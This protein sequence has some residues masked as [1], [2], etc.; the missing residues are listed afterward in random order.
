MASSTWS[1]DSSTWSGNSYIW[2]NSTYQVTANM[3]QVNLSNAFG[4]DLD[5]SQLATIGGS[6]GMSGTTAHVMPASVLLNN[7]NTVTNSQT[8]QL[9]VSGTLAGTS[10]IKN[11][12]NFEESGTMGMTGSAS[13]DNTFLW[14]DVAEDTDTLWTKIS[15]PDE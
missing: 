6:Y 5:T 2:N 7:T 1:A 9:P 11:N 3:T 14:N 4:E 8:A 13:S 10:N 15:D 12:V